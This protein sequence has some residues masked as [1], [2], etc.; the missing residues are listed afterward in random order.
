[1]DDVYG[2][3]VESGSLVPAFLAKKPAT[4]LKWK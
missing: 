4:Q 2:T 1:M 3:V